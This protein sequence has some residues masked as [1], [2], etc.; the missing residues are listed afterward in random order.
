MK[1]VIWLKL[2]EEFISVEKNLD[3][4]ILRDSRSPAVDRAA[5]IAEQGLRWR[6]SREQGVAL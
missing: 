5:R 3:T 2:M 1:L 4:P 6:R